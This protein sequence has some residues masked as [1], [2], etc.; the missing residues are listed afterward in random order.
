MATHAE[1]AAAAATA[2]LAA[3]ND[4]AE[5]A[6][7]AMQ[8]AGAP[9]PE[10]VAAMKAAEAM[11]AAAAQPPPPP[12]PPPNPM[13]L[14]ANFEAAIAQAMQ[15]SVASLMPAMAAA[16]AM[17]TVSALTAN[18][19]RFKAAE[20]LAAPLRKRAWED[21]ADPSKLVAGTVE[22][23]GAV[24]RA[25]ARGADWIQR[26]GQRGD[27]TIA[28]MEL[29]LS[30]IPVV[31]VPP[32]PHVWSPVAEQRAYDA[33]DGIASL[34][35]LLLRLKH[36]RNLIMV[37]ARHHAVAECWDITTADAWRTTVRRV[38][39]DELKAGTFT[40]AW[41]AAGTMDPTLKAI[42][43]QR[44][45]VA[46]LTKRLQPPDANFTTP[47]NKKIK[48]KDTKGG[49][50]GGGGGKGGGGKGGK[51]DK[52]K[53]GK[54]GGGGGGGGGGGADDDDDD[55]DDADD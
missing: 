29:A 19:E 1:N 17:P 5:A 33:A 39:L 16:T 46:L 11:A 38:I 18:A 53:R 36:E 31:P 8:A 47:I 32:R 51:R 4:P 25:S 14:P 21:L 13:G 10:A 28:R 30:V 6:F 35:E 3:G 45:D 49:G 42:A 27:A 43:E 26:I 41:P 52:S 24:S 23:T 9:F 44:R 37:D 50:R 2:A 34:R 20:L 54:R 15:A 40:F 55:A 22:N 12:L 48:T 7:K